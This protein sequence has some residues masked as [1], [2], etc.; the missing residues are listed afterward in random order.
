[1]SCCHKASVNPSLVLGAH[2]DGGV[3]VAVTVVAVL[4]P[5][6]AACAVSRSQYPPLQLRSIAPCLVWRTRCR[7]R[8]PSSRGTRSWPPPPPR[9][10]TAAPRP[11][12]TAAR[13]D[14]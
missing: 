14:M 13:A 10:R 7:S 3:V 2:T 4:E 12:T 9:A 11:D 6:V 5:L 8:R 1:M